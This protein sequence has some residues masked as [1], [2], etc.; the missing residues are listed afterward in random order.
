DAGSIV[1]GG[2]DMTAVPAHRRNIGMV[3]QQYALFPHLTV[4]ENVAFGLRMRRVDKAEQVLR[5]ADALAVVRLTGLGERYPRQLSGGQQQ[6]VALARALVLRPDMLLLDEPLSNL[7]A[8]LRQEM[9]T[10]LLQILETVGITTILVTHDQ[11]EALALSQR[12]AVMN[13]GR[14]EQAGEP[15][16]V[17]RRPA[18]AFVA[19]FLGDPN[20]LAGRVAEATPDGLVCALPNGWRIRAEPRAGLTPGEPAEIV[21]RSERLKLSDAPDGAGNVF[22]VALEHVIYLG[23]TTRYVV[24]GGDLRLVVLAHDEATGRAPGDR[25]FLHWEPRDTLVFAADAP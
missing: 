12:L 1:V 10:E 6:R 5:V 15:G 23:V 2:R 13:L 4:A 11:E 7:D 16:E 18:S 14:I 19:K 22:P 24:R 9:R 17:Y 21:L 20:A 8:K 3:F 25:L